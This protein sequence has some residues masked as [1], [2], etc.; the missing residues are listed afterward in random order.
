MKCDHCDRAVAGPL[1]LVTA[2]DG[3]QFCGRRACLDAFEEEYGHR[4]KPLIQEL[5]EGT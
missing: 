2:S 1:E 3:K 4:R 5:R